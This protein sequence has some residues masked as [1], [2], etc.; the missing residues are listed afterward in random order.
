MKK[1]RTLIAT[2]FLCKDC[3]QEFKSTDEDRKKCAMCESRNIIKLG[4]GTIRANVEVE[5][6]EDED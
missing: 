2:V 1:L 6:P 4:G 5:D 3:E